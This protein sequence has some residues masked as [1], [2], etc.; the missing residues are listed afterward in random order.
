M[1]GLASKAVLLAGDIFVISKLIYKIGIKLLRKYPDS[2]LDY[3]DLLAELETLDPVF[4][5]IP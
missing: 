3:Q 4:V 5:K 1:D 2:A